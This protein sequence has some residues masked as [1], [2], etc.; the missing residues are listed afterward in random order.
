MTESH[1]FPDVESR[2]MTERSLYQSEHIGLIKGNPQ[3]HHR[4]AGRDRRL[5]SVSSVGQNNWGVGS[6]RFYLDV[7]DALWAVHSP[8][9][10]EKSQ[11]ITI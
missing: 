4:E 5:N 10:L 1:L 2:F 7:P 9:I 8:L 11:S 3:F 6:I